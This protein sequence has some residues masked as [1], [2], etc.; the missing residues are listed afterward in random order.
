MKFHL[1]IQYIGRDK[2]YA[3]RTRIGFSVRELVDINFG[4]DSD[5]LIKLYIKQAQKVNKDVHGRA[6]NRYK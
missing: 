2:F 5:D 4:R 1:S 3:S 6:K